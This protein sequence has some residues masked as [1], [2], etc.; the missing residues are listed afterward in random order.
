M[1]FCGPKENHICI[2]HYRPTVG[3]FVVGYNKMLDSFRLDKVGDFARVIVVNPLHEKLP[4]LVLIA[5]CTYGYFNSQW[6]RQ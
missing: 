4:R 6:V 3:I 5:C 2:S 1:G